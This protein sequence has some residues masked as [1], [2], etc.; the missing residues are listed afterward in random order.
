VLDFQVRTERWL[1]QPN[2]GTAR[3]NNVSIMIFSLPIQRT[4]R[5]KPADYVGLFKIQTPADVGLDS[6][7]VQPSDMIHNPT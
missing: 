6:D 3:A 2:R 4:G 7:S 1:K 5:E